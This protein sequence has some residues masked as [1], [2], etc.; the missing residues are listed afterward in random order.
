MLITRAVVAL[1]LLATVACGSSPTAPTPAPIQVVVAAPTTGVL[2]VKVNSSCVGK[3]SGISVA[4]D[5]LFVG[6]EEPNGNGVSRTVSI[7]DHTVSG[8]SRE[9]FRWGPLSKTVPASGFNEVFSCS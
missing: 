5:G 6:V 3:A 9:G 1:A 4:I 8:V 2:T 7:G